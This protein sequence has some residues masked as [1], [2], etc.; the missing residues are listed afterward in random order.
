[1]TQ[2]GNTA[3][4]LEGTGGRYR[5]LLPHGGEGE[6]SL[7]GRLKKEENLAGRVVAGDRVRVAEGAD[8]TLT[9]EELLPRDSE[10]VRAGLRGRHPKVVAANLTG[11]FV[12]HSLDQ[13]AFRGDRV[14]RFLAL[15]ESCGIPPTLVLN[16]VELPGARER[17]EAEAKRYG[18][19][20]YPVLLTSARTGEGIKAFTEALA[21]GT[22]ALVGPSGVGK[23]SLLNAVDPSL[24]L[25]VGEVSRRSG[26]GRHTTVSAVLHPVASGGWVV[27]TPGFSEVSLWSVDPASLGDCF[28]EFRE[29]AEACRFREC[30]HLHEPEC[31]VREAL[32]RGEIDAERFASYRA[33][34]EGAEG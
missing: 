24:G 3:T 29:P 13:P 33:L 26:G 4:V 28:P 22:W 17:G 19:V 25:R 1:M 10:L 32:E 8:G 21:G 11:I 14:D 18:A 12:V 7:R 6:A 9:I 2:A 34:R 23:S 15:A 20:G 30:S 27:D 16:K 5:L 31:G